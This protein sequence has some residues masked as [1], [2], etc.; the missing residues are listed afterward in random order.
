[1]NFAAPANTAFGTAGARDLA[2][3][4]LLD[5]ILGVNVATQP[6][7]AA[8]RAELDALAAKLTSCGAGCAADRTK[9]VV[10]ASCAA[11]LGSAA[12]LLQ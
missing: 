4:P 5:R 1:M 2:F 7:R 6:N 12:T 10:K 8:A 9:T 11:L 3:N